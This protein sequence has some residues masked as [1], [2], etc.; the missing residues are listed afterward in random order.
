[1]E[2]SEDQRR[3][4]EERLRSMSPE[5]L[6]EYQ[7]KQCIFCR[8]VSGEIPAK[9]IYEDEK[10]FAILDIN[11]AA[12][13]H[14]LLLPKEHYLLLQQMP[15]EDIGRLFLIARSFSQAFL[16]AL[17]A[18]GSTI[19][20]ASGQAAG[21]RA[22][23]VMIHLI[24]RKEGDS[25]GLKPKPIL[26]RPQDLEVVAKA[27]K[28]FADKALGPSQNAE[29]SS[30]TPASL[31]PAKDAPSPSHRDS[32]DKIE[33]IGKVEDVNKEPEED[34]AGNQVEEK[35]KEKKPGQSSL[36]DIADFLARK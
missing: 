12:P 17:R 22:Q 10:L 31:K 36:D 32:K 4:L 18:E 19:F 29:K 14:V 24:P 30:P 2:M 25:V 8:I 33:D 34:H 26:A 5:E 28:P 9:K 35:K 6:R 13:G 23:H 11:P 27:M 21:Q 16:Q 3:E 7:K 1:M 15:D 20:C